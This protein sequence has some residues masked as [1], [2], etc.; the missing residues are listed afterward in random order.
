MPCMLDVRALGGSFQRVLVG[1]GRGVDADHRAT[2]LLEVGELA[3]LPQPEGRLDVRHVVLEA[4]HDDLVEP[5]PGA[6]V[7]APG[8]AAH[9]VQTHGPRALEEPRIAGEHAAPGRREVLGGVDAEG[10]EFRTRSAGAALVL[11]GRA[12]SA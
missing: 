1:E 8:I 5:A 12:W 10:D 6:I 2:P 3:Q 11:P 9:A 4:G 7:A